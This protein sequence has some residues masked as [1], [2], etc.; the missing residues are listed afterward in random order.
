MRQLRVVGGALRN[1]RLQAIPGSRPTSERAREA[2]FDIL[3]DEVVGRDV[4]ELFAGS[5]AVAIEA[6]SR[7]ARSAAAVDRDASALRLNRDRLGV[8]LEIIEGSAA[9][10]VRRLVARARRF[11][12]IFVDPPYGANLPA[13]ANPGPEQFAAILARGGLLVWQIDA[14]SVPEPGGP[15]EVVRVARYGRNVFHFY[16]ARA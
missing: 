10:A 5:G 7:G 13:E 11:D 1:R 14:R 8:P 6:F 15:L 3:G 16:R 12:L 9:A 4:I 2:L